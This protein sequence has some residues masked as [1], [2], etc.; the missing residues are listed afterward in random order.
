MCHNFELKPLKTTPTPIKN[1]M[2]THTLIDQ[3]CQQLGRAI[4]TCA[5]PASAVRTSPAH[6]QPDKVM[7]RKEKKHASGLMR[8]NHT[9]EICAQGLYQGQALASKNPYNKKLLLDAAK[10]ELD[11]LAWT[12]HRLK[13]LNNQ[14]SLFNPIWYASSFAL[15]FLT[16]KIDEA[17]SLGFVIETENQVCEH[18]ESHLSSFKQLPIQDERSRM[19]VKQMKQ[20]ELEHAQHARESG[21]VELPNAVKILMTGA[22]KIMTTIAYR[23]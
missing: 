18:L 6:T 20:E 21:G 17:I 15:G 1:K 13:E 11:H 5:A 8:I 3:F 2:H 22:A 14:T 12:E 23:I 9:G 4:Q 10:E 19:L 16:G 7:T